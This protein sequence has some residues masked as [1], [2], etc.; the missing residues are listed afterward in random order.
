MQTIM[1]QLLVCRIIK[2]LKEKQRFSCLTSL[3]SRFLQINISEIS[4][5]PSVTKRVKIITCLIIVHTVWFS[6][7]TA[8]SVCVSH[9]PPACGWAGTRSGLCGRAEQSRSWAWSSSGG[10]RKWCP[11]DP[12]LFLRAADPRPRRPCQTPFPGLLTSETWTSR[13]PSSGLPESSQSKRT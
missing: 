8:V 5:L 13:S 7:N 11:P 9:L 1:R 2:Q 6:W 10:L 4:K 12:G 3:Y